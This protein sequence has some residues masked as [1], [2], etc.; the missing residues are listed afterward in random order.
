MIKNNKKKKDE[1]RCSKK[2]QVFFEIKLADQIIRAKKCHL[3][4]S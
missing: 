2:L 3:L 4:H 1:R